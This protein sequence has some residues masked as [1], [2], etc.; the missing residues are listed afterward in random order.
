MVGT[1]L[2]AAAKG[3]SLWVTGDGVA[4]V[5][6]LVDSQINTDPRRGTGEDSPLNALAPE[7]GAEIILELERQGMTAYSVPQAGQKVRSGDFELTVVETE[8]ARIKTVQI[9]IH[10]EETEQ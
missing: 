4:N 2:V 9:F 7:K 1:E 6:A 10:H 5:I 3:E 8:R